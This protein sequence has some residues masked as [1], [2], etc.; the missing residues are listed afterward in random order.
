MFT[1]PIK[2]PQGTYA[3]PR[4][5]FDCPTHFVSGC[6]T[7]D[8]EDY[9]NANNFSLNINLDLWGEFDDG[10]K[11]VQTC[12]CSKIQDDDANIFTWMPGRYCINRKNDTCPAGFST[13]Y[14]KWDDESTNNKH[15]AVEGEL[16]DG[17]YPI[18]STLINFCCRDDGSPEDRILLP[19]TSP[20]VLYPYKE[21]KCQA[22]HGMEFTQH[23]VHTDDE[24]V[25]NQ[26]ECDGE[27]PYMDCSEPDFNITYCYY[28]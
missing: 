27:V 24:D 21:E 6:R 10:D 26:N 8:N 28:Y 25:D 14:V 15:G 20:F 12:Y 4:T 19:N 17:E 16:P 2:W 5:W 3:L 9:E 23:F 13:G 7:Q 22:V 1:I 11:N 18:G